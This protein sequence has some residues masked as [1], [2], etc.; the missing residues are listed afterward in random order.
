MYD[1]A[2]CYNYFEREVNVG[3]YRDFDVP[4][5]V[6][7]GA[8][9]AFDA[10]IYYWDNNSRRPWEDSLNDQY[11]YER[12]RWDFDDGNGFVFATQDIEY[13]DF[14]LNEINLFCCYD[15]KHWVIMLPCE[16]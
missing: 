14:P 1:S 15:G 6:C 16:Y 9:L 7:R 3:W 8:E 2:N 5:V 11:G 13:T 10:T 12:V 4:E